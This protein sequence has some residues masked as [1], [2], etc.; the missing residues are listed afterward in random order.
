MHTAPMDA[1]VLCSDRALEARAP[2]L[3]FPQAS[4]SISSRTRLVFPGLRA[5]SLSPSS[6]RSISTFTVSVTPPEAK[7]LRLP[8][9]VLKLMSAVIAISHVLSVSIESLSVNIM[10][11]ESS[12]GRLKCDSNTLPMPGFLVS[13]P[14]SASR[15]PVS[16]AILIFLIIIFQC[17]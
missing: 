6:P 2:S 15:S 4:L 14:S 8:F 16:L 12:F 7:L 13:S 1:V 10:L 5:A 9:L 17:G 3:P 11:H